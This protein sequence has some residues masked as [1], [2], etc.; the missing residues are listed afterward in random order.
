M[1]VKAWC[2]LSTLNRSL[3]NE[4]P[5]SPCTKLRCGTG[6]IKDFDEPKVPFLVRYDQNCFDTSN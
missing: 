1:S 3:R 5:A 6:L 2:L 4:T